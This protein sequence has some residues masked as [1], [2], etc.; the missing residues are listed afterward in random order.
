MCHLGSG[1]S[2]FFK[3]RNQTE[4]EIAELASVH[5]SHLSPVHAP[6]TVA[7]MEG[8]MGPRCFLNGYISKR[9][10][11]SLFHVY[12]RHCIC[13]SAAQ[14]TNWCRFRVGAIATSAACSGILTYEEWQDDP[15][16]DF[17]CS[18]TNVPT[19]PRDGSELLY[20]FEDLTSL[21]YNHILYGSHPGTQTC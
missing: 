6:S 1:R 12:S 21:G 3:V 13:V 5:F 15:L 11:K 8:I 2:C 10:V 14:L 16:I 18:A 17:I 4:I 7:L 19:P 9:I 20:T